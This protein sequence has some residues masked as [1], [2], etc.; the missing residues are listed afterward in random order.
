MKNKTLLILAILILALAAC[1][2]SQPAA[3]PTSVPPTPLPTQA[4]PASPA[5]SSLLRISFPDASTGWALASANTG[6][7]L[8]TSDGG[9]TWLDVTP[10]GLT[11]IGYSTTL[12]VLNVA[13]AWVLAPNADYLS[14]KLYRT[15][16]AGLT[17]TSFDAPFGGGYL[18]FLDASTGFALADLGA[19]AGSQAVEL[20]QTTDGGATWL[21]VFNDDPTRPDSSGS[22]PLGGIKSGMTFLDASTGWVTGERPVNGEVYL[23]VTHN[24]GLDWAEQTIP[25]PSGYDAYMYLPQAPVFFGND[26]FLPLMVDLPATSVITFYTT[27]DGGSTWSGNPS[28][29]ASQVPLGSR[30]T[31]ADSTHG[32][33]WDG[34]ASIYVTT[35]AAQTWSAIPTSL[36]LGDNLAQ[37]V[38]VPASG[39]AYNGWALTGQDS[40]GHSQLYHTT[41]NGSTWTQLV[42]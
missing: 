12:S 29:S 13:T 5:E 18:Q 2:L 1:N 42:P 20:F 25:L 15:S 21:S 16:D 9:A 41:D 24:G 30:Y 22:L 31:F 34:G 10:P 19:G 7:V 40:A 6:A 3:T 38:F 8:R 37:V 14:G 4:A 11:G 32:W 35:D 28:N 23:F 17:W 26:G 39:G 36:N 33:S 27:H